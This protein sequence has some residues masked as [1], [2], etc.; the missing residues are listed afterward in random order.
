[1]KTFDGDMDDY[2]R[3]VLAGPE[4]EQDRSAE[5]AG[6]QK[7][8]ARRAGVERR[9]A[10]APLRKKLDAI[11]ARMAKLTA[12]IQKIDSALEDGTAFRENAAKAGEISKM[13]ADAASALATAE[14]E[15][16]ELSGEIEAALA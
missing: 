6:G 15:W 8:E 12:A 3:L 16:L 9:A 11:E 5:A 7:A 2:R 4:R 13:R 14:E 1:V 10:V